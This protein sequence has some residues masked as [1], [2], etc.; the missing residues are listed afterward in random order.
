MPMTLS[1]GFRTFGRLTT[2][3]GLRGLIQTAS[4]RIVGHS[5]KG[6]LKHRWAITP[7]ESPSRQLNTFGALATPR[8]RTLSSASEKTSLCPLRSRVGC[9]TNKLCTTGR[10]FGQ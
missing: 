8:Y 2:T 4:D 7:E 1:A 10:Q 6:R 3:P 5:E 9:C